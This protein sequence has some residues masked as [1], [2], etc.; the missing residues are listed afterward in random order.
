VKRVTIAGD[1]RFDRDGALLFGGVLS[2][3]EVAALADRLE[4]QITGRPGTRLKVEPDMATLLAADGAVGRVAAGLIGLDAIPVRAVLFDKSPDANWIVAWHQDRTIPVRERRETP[5]FGPW[6]TKDGVL[7]VA[8]PITVLEGMVTLR[9]HLDPVD[10]DNAPLVV[11][12]GSHRFGY[13]PASEAAAR[14]AHCAALVCK[15]AAGDVWA[16]S[17]PILH[18]SARSVGERRRRVLQVD[19]AAA[20]LPK[21]LQWRG[22]GA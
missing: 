2:A 22:I 20:P 8:P 14:A 15:A 12:L 4:P 13:V 19:S 9:L 6:S 7:H 3:A 1:L 17:T 11:A 10:A 16:Y 18:M 5:G 21:P